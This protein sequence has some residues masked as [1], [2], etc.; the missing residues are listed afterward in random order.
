[1]HQQR[2]IRFGERAPA[3]LPQLGS[4]GLFRRVVLVPAGGYLQTQEVRT[5]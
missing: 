3:W 1:M 2:T 4:L 5:F